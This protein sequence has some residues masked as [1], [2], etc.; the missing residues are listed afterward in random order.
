[1]TD[2]SNVKQKAS[3]WAPF[4]FIAL[5]INSPTVAANNCS[6]D[7]FHESVKVAHVYD[8]DTIKLTDGRKLRIIGINTPERGR[9]GKK[10]QPFYQDAKNHLQQIIEKNNNQLKIILGKD[11]R[12]RYKRLL[13]HIFTLQN[14]NITS[15]M[16]KKGMGFSIAIPPNIKFNACYQKAERE[17]KKHNSGIWQHSFSQAVE[18][19][20]LS[21]TTRGFH[22]VKGTVQRIGES[23]SSYWLN[24]DEKFA[25]RILKKDLP[26]F[27]KYHPK[28]LL[29]QQVIA[30]GWIYQRKNELR[31]SIHHPASLQLQNT[32]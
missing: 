22:Q 10:D 17:A 14:E 31:M 11:K 13:A 24:L 3:N 20:S 1:M 7:T 18:A 8:G 19:A 2:R 4:V 21:E 6:A 29:N 12:D 32:D 26:Y 30:R 15:S 25:L 5:L 23:R 27:I 9:D 16:L 28:Q